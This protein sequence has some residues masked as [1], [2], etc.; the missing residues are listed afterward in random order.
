MNGYIEH[1]NITLINPR[2]TIE[3][4]LA[5]LPDW[6]I[7]GQGRMEN[8]H[9]KDVEWFHV[10]NEHSY[11]ALQSGGDKTLPDWTTH[12]TGVKHIGIAVDDLSAMVE[13]LSNA[14][15]ELEHWGGEHPHRRSAYY[16][17]EHNM[18][19]EFVEYFSEL[20]SERNDYSQ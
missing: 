17:D 20:P 6:K 19:F 5:A 18:Q 14:G 7:R 16:V 9:G 15:F 4:L 11:I 8:W 3:F 10:G 2:H 12:W 1:A 13:R